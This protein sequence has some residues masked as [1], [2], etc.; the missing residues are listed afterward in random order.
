[1]LSIP[2]IIAGRLG[3]LEARKQKSLEARRPGSPQALKFRG[4]GGFI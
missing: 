3:S 2:L 4:S 1:M